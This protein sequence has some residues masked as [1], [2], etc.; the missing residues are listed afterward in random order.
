MKSNLQITYSPHRKKLPGRL[1]LLTGIA[2]ACC[3]T[4]WQ[5]ALALAANKNPKEVA[6]VRI[7]G[8]VTD[9]KGLSLPGVSILLKGTA[10][11]AVSDLNGNFSITVPDASSGVLIFSFVGYLNKEV[12]LSGQTNIKVSLQVDSRALNE[13]V[14]VG[15]GTQKKATLTGS[16]SVIKGAE[17]VKSPAPNIS[18]SLAGRVSGVITNNGSGEPGYD[19][20]NITVRGLATTGNN[21]VLVVV[22]GIPGQIGGLERLD[23][24]DIESMSILKD[25]SAA[26]YGNRAANGVILITT[27]H[28]KLGKASVAYTFNQGF[29]SP[30]RLPKL[31][32][33]PTYAQIVNDISYYN[34]PAGGMN[35]VYSDAQIE[36]FR[37]GSD[38]LNY[39]NTDWEKTVLKDFALQNQQNLTVTGG[40]EDIK[41]YTSAGT[42]YQD[43]LYKNGAT[44][45]HQ[46]NIRANIDATVA[47][48][49]KIGLS[50]SGREE[51][52]QYPTTGAGDI[53]RSIYRSYPTSAAFYP[54]GLPTAGID[55]NNPGLTGTSIGGT[56]SNPIQTFN[57]ILKGSYEIPGVRGLSLEGFFSADKSGNFDKAFYTPYTVYTYNSSTGEYVPSVEGGTGGKPSLFESQLNQSL[58]TKNIKLNYARDFGKHNINAFVAYEQSQNTY[59]YFFANRL[60]FPTATT[61]ELSQGGTAASDATNGGSSS[62]NNGNYNY[63][64]RSVISRLAYNYDEKVPA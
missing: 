47:K 2:L 42:T 25:A 34:S 57:G 6:S 56:N 14:V 18:N 8:Q 41:Y 53:F 61:P 13:I 23:P 24:N 11:G 26:V 64:R 45:Y 55:Q 5:P 7:S 39:P 16:V 30:T 43:G 49:F 60:N 4:C 48:G 51:D 28:G 44:N 1:R 20:S 38:P 54:N 35:Q 27:K 10:T 32:D 59:N 31:A 3:I 50:L 22:D 12:A 58:I 33:A 17:M 40:T 9:D 21:S 37:N 63:N 19:G 29:S 15:Y 46:Y 62:D 52:R 36:K